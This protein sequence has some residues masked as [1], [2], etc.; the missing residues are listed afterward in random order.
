MVSLYNGGKQQKFR[1]FNLL[2]VKQCT[3]I[4]SNM[5]HANIKVS[6]RAKAKRIKA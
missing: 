2:I 5:Q 1:Q 6:I 3:E 4:P